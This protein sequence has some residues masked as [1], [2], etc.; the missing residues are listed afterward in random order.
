MTCSENKSLNEIRRY[1]EDK[2]KEK[3]PFSEKDGTIVFSLP[4]GAS[5]K[6]VQLGGDFNALVMDYV[7]EDGDTFSP[8]D[9]KTLDELFEA[10]F[11]ETK[12]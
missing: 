6:V 4:D 5:M 12:S 2:F 8:D 9:Y 10:M 11:E 1:I 3:Y 7:G